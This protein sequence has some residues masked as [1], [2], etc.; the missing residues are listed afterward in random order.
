MEA[1]VGREAT[2]ET[3]DEHG[4]GRDLS[5]EVFLALL[6]LHFEGKSRAQ[7]SLWDFSI[8]GALGN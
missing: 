1:F 3:L 4:G 6:L 5:V 7:D 8:R 2:P